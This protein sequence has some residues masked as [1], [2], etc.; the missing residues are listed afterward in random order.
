MTVARSPGRR[1]RRPRVALLLALALLVPLTALAALT[2]GSAVRSRAQQQ[3]SAR[4]ERDSTELG[5]LMAARAMIVNE[6]VPSSA[7]AAAAQFKITDEQVK[8]LFG[9]DFPK[10]LRAARPLVDASP[11]L[12]SD[13]VLIADLERLHQ[14]RPS[15]GTGRGDAETIRAFFENFEIDIDNVWRA[16]FQSMQGDIEQLTGKTGLV[17]ERVDALSHS[18][19][20][21]M[22]ATSRAQQSDLVV[23]GPGTPAAAKALIEANGTFA[24]STAGFP[25][26][27]GPKAT[28]AWT[29]WEKDPQSRAWE[30][31]IAQTVDTALA[32]LRSPLATNTLAYGV[33]FTKEP[34]WLNELTAVTVG[35][36]TDMREVA[37]REALSAARSYRNELTIFALSVL[38]AAGAT[39][40][41]A[42]AV[43]RPLRRLSA[44]A[45]RVAEGD[46]A[47]QSVRPGGPR[48]VADTIAAVDEMTSVFSAV[49]A[50]TVTLAEN[51]DAS[52][53]RRTASRPHRAG[54]ADHAQP[55]AGIRAPRRAPAGDPARD[56]HPRLAHRLAQ[57]ASRAVGRHP[58]T[59]D[60]A[61]RVAGRDD[62]LHRPRQP[63][64]HQR[65]L[66]PQS[67]GRR[68]PPH[69]PG[70]SH[71]R[72]G[73]RHRGQGRRRRVPRGGSGRSAR[74]GTGAGRPAAP[75]RRGQPA[76]RRRRARY[77]F[78]AASA[79][80]TPHPTTTS[81]PSSTRRIRRCTWPSNSAVT[82]ARGT[83]TQRIASRAEPACGLPPERR[84]D[85]LAQRAHRR[86]HRRRLVAA[87]GHAVVAARVLPR[88]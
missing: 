58:R 41:L 13:P 86:D 24:A 75:H 14:L 53:T 62:A 3:I 9:I 22:A 59:R 35:A 32:G 85:R 45:R 48:E 23:N 72:A 79:S 20:V 1:W 68:D 33:A 44:S 38:I 27:L 31:T 17:A 7:L 69:R 47:L 70:A 74:R 8:K 25:A 84:P 65:Q 37:H 28:E 80:A 16:R 87:V 67:R 71:C 57:P 81:A 15:I 11:A 82:A 5:A 54:A 19:A 21:L 40:L 66:R 26:G 6:Y 49:E 78:A 36:S 42:R 61:A 88:P 30:Q 34:H 64:G 73:V 29:A 56:G 2:G 83:T 60:G 10:Q 52:L 51:P 43:V 50:F 46:F 55:A 76:G 39:V 63:Q 4:V 18:F 77:P 12:R